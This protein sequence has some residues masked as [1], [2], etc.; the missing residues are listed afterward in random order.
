MLGIPQLC[1]VQLLLKTRQ[2]SSSIHLDEYYALIQEYLPKVS[3]EQVSITLKRLA[4][5]GMVTVDDFKNVTFVYTDENREEVNH[6]LS[7]A[8]IALDMMN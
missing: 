4:A 2:N 7:L 5:R 8:E 6:A 3:K 1:M